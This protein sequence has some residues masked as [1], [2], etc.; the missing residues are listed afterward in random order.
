LVNSLVTSYYLNSLR[1]KN[2]LRY[3]ENICYNSIYLQAEF[4]I[5]RKMHYLYESLGRG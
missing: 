5:K 3:L 1:D 4:I 2:N